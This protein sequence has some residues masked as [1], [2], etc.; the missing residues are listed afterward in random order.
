MRSQIT[1]AIR[2]NDDQL[3]DVA[4][5]SARLRCSKAKVWQLIAHGEIESLTIGRARRVRESELHAYL[6]RRAAFEA[7]SR[8]NSGT[9]H[10]S[11]P[12]GTLPN[13]E[14]DPVSQTIG[15]GSEV[16]RG[17]GEPNQA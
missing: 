4:A 2:V 6:A 7:Q 17:G 10:G 14:A 13:E 15:V 5:V 9:P 8:T 16:R 1:E 12:Q 3:L 11:G